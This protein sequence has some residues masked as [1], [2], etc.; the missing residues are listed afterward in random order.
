MD[1]AKAP[2]GPLTWYV[3]PIT[4]DSGEKCPILDNWK[5]F[6]QFTIYSSAF[7]GQLFRKRN[8]LIISHKRTWIMCIVSTTG[9]L[10]LSVVPGILLV[11]SNELPVYIMT[12]TEGFSLNSC[13]PWDLLLS[14]QSGQLSLYKVLLNITI[15]LF[16]SSQ[17]KAGH[18]SANYTALGL[19]FTLLRSLWKPVEPINWKT[20]DRSA[21]QAGGSEISESFITSP[22]R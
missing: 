1:I 17:W 2:S 11:L 3:L 22:L 18:P 8:Y 20:Y 12:L 7:L 9:F 5:W 16:C 4:R 15:S 13:S 6:S 21:W 19:K 10:K 14:S